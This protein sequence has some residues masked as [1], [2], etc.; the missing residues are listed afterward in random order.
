M[1]RQ[2][3]DREFADVIDDAWQVTYRVVRD[4]RGHL[5][6]S[7]VTI[8]PVVTPAK[9]FTI[10]DGGI[11]RDVI[12]RI[13]VGANR[14]FATHWIASQERPKTVP[15]KRHGPGRPPTMTVADYRTLDRQYRALLAARHP[16][17]AKE[18]ANQYGITRTAMRSRLA[19]R[20]AI[21]RG[22]PL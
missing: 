11:T 2:L 22:G 6:V 21:L 9:P 19:R 12:R 20:E 18:L 10:P 3:Y 15:A 4:A 7:G 5:V 8:R 1:A 17:P 13:Q 14:R 16:C